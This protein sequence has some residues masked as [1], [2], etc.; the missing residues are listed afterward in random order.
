MIRPSLLSISQHCGLAPVLA[1]NDPRGSG[2]RARVGTAYHAVAAGASVA[3]VTDG[4]TTAELE[5]LSELRWP[6]GIPANAT[7]E[8]RLG[9]SPT[10]RATAPGKA[11]NLTEGTPDVYWLLPER[12][13]GSNTICVV[14]YKTGSLPME[15]GPMSLQLVAY[16]FAVADELGAEAMRLG[17]WYARG[18][19]RWDWSDVIPL[20]SP[21]AADLWKRVVAAATAPPTAQVGPW[22]EG[23]WQRDICPAR[24]LPAIDG[25]ALGELEPFVAG[26]GTAL[27][28]ERGEVGLRL[29]S[30]MREVADRAEEHI[31]AEV[32]AGRLRMERDGKV[33]G[34]SEV[35]GRRSASVEDLTKAGL[36]QYVKQG[37]PYSRWGWTKVRR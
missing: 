14:D 6:G 29:I 28:P 8:R 37:R 5:E 24:L 10:G 35:A 20:D 9:L 27:T 19:G 11:G 31:R 4:L 30:A 15:D 16:G 1:A 18:E 26:S 12:V 7:R 32:T 33:Y 22:C 36:T 2:S 13:D 34:P 23:C 17:I 3:D 25:T 21:E